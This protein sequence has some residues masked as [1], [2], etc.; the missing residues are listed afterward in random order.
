MGETFFSTH[1]KHSLNFSPFT[2]HLHHARRG[3]SKCQGR[4]FCSQGTSGRAHLPRNLVPIICLELCNHTIPQT[5][6]SCP[7]ILS[8]PPSTCSRVEKVLL[9]IQ[10]TSQPSFLLVKKEE[11]RLYTCKYI[12]ICICM[13]AYTHTHIY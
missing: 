3:C 12:Y 1:H 8:P 11:L 4:I 7:P 9:Q 10:E 6:P 13:H 2:H 5:E